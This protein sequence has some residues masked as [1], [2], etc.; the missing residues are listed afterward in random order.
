LVSFGH[1]SNGCGENDIETL[2]IPFTDIALREAAVMLLA[3]GCGVLVRL[4]L[5]LAGQHWARTY[6]NTLT[7][8]LLPVVGLVIVQVISGSIALSLGMIGALSIVRFRHPVKSPLELVIFFLLL[9]I[10]VA[11]SS[12]TWL[13]LALTI[14]SCGLILAV[15]WFQNWRRLSG[16][17]PFPASPGDGSPQFLL[18]VTAREPVAFGPYEESLIFSSEDLDARHF[19]YKFAFSSRNELAAARGLVATNSGIIKIAGSF[20]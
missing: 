19:S 13:G 6:S 12:R 17:D 16:K 7:Y 14:V 10:G 5:G 2:V 11:L 8:L 1:I 20:A 9:T 15:T 3:I 18:E 4:T